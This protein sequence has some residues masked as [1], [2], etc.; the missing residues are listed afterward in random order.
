MQQHIR[1]MEQNT[2]ASL[3]PLFSPNFPPLPPPLLEVGLEVQAAQSH[4]GVSV[5]E[6]AGQ[7]Q[8]HV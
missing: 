1:V 8:L 2:E 6:Q 3:I 4:N 5:V 7:V